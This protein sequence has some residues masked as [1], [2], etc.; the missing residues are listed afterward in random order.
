MASNIVAITGAA[1]YLGRLT[2]RHLSRPSRQLKLLD[3][4]DMGPAGERETLIRS[5][6]TDADAVARLVTDA[7]VVVHLAADLS[8]D[9][10]AGVLASNL[11]GTYNVYEAA[12]AAGVK[13]I[14]FASSHHIAGMYPSRVV[15]D[16]LAPHRPDSLYGLSKGFGEDLGQYY[17]DK[18]GL[19]SVAL[20]IGSARPAPIDPR[21]RYTW[22]SEP[23]YC[24]LIDACLTAPR[25]GFT[26]VWGVSANDGVWWDNRHAAHLG[27]AP[28]DNAG[29]HMPAPAPL[30]AAAERLLVYQGG[31]RSLYRLAESADERLA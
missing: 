23:D 1:G 19:E 17:W 9:D 25:V 8:V 2:R 14:V 29:D 22:L 24:R 15:T 26:P 11:E 28:Q 20:R 16:T 7:D 5:S 18:F 30:D 6:L 12:R 27:F 4:A 21:E 31:K 3:I 10:W 13:R